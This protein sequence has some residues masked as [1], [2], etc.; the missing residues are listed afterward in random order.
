MTMSMNIFPSITTIDE[1]NDDWD[2]RSVTAGNISIRV[3]AMDTSDVT[4]VKIIAYV[5]DPA[6]PLFDQ[7]WTASE[8]TFRGPYLTAASTDYNLWI[9]VEA[10]GTATD[11]AEITVEL[12][13]ENP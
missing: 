4:S 1:N 9:E 10:A 5:S 7:T 13:V 8:T 6:S 3:S 11:P 12:K 2:I